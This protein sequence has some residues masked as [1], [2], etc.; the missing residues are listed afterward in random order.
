MMSTLGQVAPDVLHELAVR[1]GVCVRPILSRLT[2]TATGEQLVVPIPCGSTQAR[3]CPVCADR[4]RKL[5]MQQC[6]E[7]WH[8]DDE[9]PADDQADDLSA[10]LSENGDEDQADDTESARRTRSTRR[11]QDA[12]DLPKVPMDNRTVGTAFTTPDGKT[13]R[14]SMFLTLTLPSYGRVGSDGTPI[15]PGTYDYHRAAMDAL[16]FPKIV[17]RFWQNLRRCAGYKVQYFATVEAQRRLAPHLHAAVRGVIPR[18][19]VKDVAAAT[20]HQLWWPQC[21]EPVYVG[22]DVPRWDDLAGR[23]VDQ[24]GRFLPTWDQALDAIGEDPAA[25]PAHVVKLGS[26]VDYQGIIASADDKVGKAVGYLTKYLSK[27]IA[28]TYGDDDEITTRQAIHLDR[29]HREVRWLPC[30]PGCS[31]W[32]RYG[33]QPKDAEGGMRPGWCPSKAHDRH[34]LG[35][36]GR[37]VLV[38]RQWTGKTLAEHRADRAEVVRQTLAAAGVDMPDTDRY[39]ATA[40]LEDGRPRFIWEPVDRAKDTDLPTWHGV[41]TR[42]INERIRW[43][44][45]YEQA[46]QR[47]NAPPDDTRSATATTAAPAA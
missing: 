13:Y 22:E 41:M 9:I 31:N 44:T 7:G 23:Y 20:Y 24:A 5:R 25:T 38:S 16:H 14:P 3:Q 34:H 11:R 27:S 32:L 33:V 29:L 10:E 1:N 17:D 37:R 46:K 30:S 39:A 19:T 21:T 43:Q 12:P 40:E 36:G 45:A 2:D 26:Q 35:L 4:A 28:D 18:Q 8:R 47:P 6:R 42:G 15:N